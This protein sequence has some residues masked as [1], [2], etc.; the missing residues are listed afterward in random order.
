[1]AIA[2]VSGFAALILPGGLGAR[3]E[4]LQ[5]MLAGQLA[6]TEGSAAPPVAALVAVALRIVWTVFEVALALALWR[7]PPTADGVRLEHGAE[8]QA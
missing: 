5:T 4:V 7:L 2:Y 8:G 3:E 6:R 1:M